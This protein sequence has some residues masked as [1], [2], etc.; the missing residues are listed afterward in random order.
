MQGE[1]KKSKGCYGTRGNEYG[2]FDLKTAKMFG[3]GE[4]SCHML[5]NS[6]LW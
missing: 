3:E 6:R 2:D 4:A 5:E 1:I